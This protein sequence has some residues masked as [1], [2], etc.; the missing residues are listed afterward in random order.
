MRVVAA[1]LEQKYPESNERTTANVILLRDE[2]S[3]Q[4]RFLLIGL[5]CASMCVLLIACSNLAN[6]LLARAMARR[7]ELAVRSALGAGR[8][9][10]VRQLLTESV[11]LA[12][13]GGCL[14]IL[15]TI[16]AMPLLVR[17]VPNTLPIAETPTIDLRVMFFALVATAFTGIGFGMIPALKTSRGTDANGLNEGSRSGVGGRKERLRSAMIIA[18]VSASVVLLISAGLLLRALLR[19]QSVDP[20][21]KYENVLTLRTWLPIPKYRA[22]AKRAEFYRQVLSEARVLPGVKNAAYVTGLPMVMRGMIWPIEV[23]GKIWERGEEHNSSLRY[24][25]PGYFDTLKI[26]II[27]GRDVSESDPRTRRLWRLLA[28]L[29]LKNIFKDRMRWTTNLKWQ[30]ESEKL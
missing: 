18:E 27:E 4:A 3:K 7:K 6:L 24:I 30:W 22:T 17:L 29:L 26:P 2:I 28:S 25:T 10:L 23:T 15:L 9:R 16:L 1:Q 19:I 8:E 11:L 13:L 20:G 21:F 14:G 5:V 12:I